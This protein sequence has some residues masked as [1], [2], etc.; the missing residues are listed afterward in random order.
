M[1]D[2]QLIAIADR[3]L[4]SFEKMAVALGGLNETYRQ[5]YEK[6]Y[7]EHR[8]AKEA[9]VTRVRNEEDRIREAQGSTDESLDAWLSEVEG[10]EE[11]SGFT[12]VRER[13]WLNAQKR[14]NDVQGA[15]G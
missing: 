14:E 8:E 5:H 11:E 15:A 6:L 4:L 7:Q 1:T 9:I 10:E 13:E 12:G 3:F 2:D